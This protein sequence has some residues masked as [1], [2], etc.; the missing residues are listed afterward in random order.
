[1]ELQKKQ[2]PQTDLQQ[3]LS[4]GIQANGNLDITRIDKNKINIELR[5]FKTLNGGI[6]YSLIFA[7]PK[8]NRITA[9]AQRNFPETS[10]II[11]VAISLAQDGMNLIRPMTSSQ[12]FDLAEAIIDDAA[13]DNISLEDLMLFLQKLIRGEYTDVYEGLDVPKVMK[14]FGEY[15]DTRWEEG[16]RLRDEKDAEF[17]RLGDNNYFE[18]SNNSSPIGEELSRYTNKIQM[19]KDELKTKEAEL[20]RLRERNKI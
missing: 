5:K 7:I 6:D 13:H 8:E 9:M 4:A 3:S 15:R 19:Q 2:Q 11:S 18:R 1:M 14:R 16:I 17:K 10:G 20:R 12:I